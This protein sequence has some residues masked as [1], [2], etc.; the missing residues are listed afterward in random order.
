MQHESSVHTRRIQESAAER[1]DVATEADLDRLEAI[2]GGAED[3]KLYRGALGRKIDEL[4]ATTEEEVDALRVNMRQDDQDVRSTRYGTGLIGDDLAAERLAGFTESGPELPDKGVVSVVPGREDTS[5]V[6]RKH[7]P[8]SS[9]A[10]SQ[11]VVEGNL[12][13]PRDQNRSEPRV[14]EGTAA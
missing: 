14:D 2:T 7:H 3:P 12:D 5:K 8:N 1:G 10:R 6:L 4:D 11:D 13:E 9:V